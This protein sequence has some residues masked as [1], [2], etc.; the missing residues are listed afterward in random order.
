MCASLMGPICGDIANVFIRGTYMISEVK[1]LA[2]HV[3]I[4]NVCQHVLIGVILV[5]CNA[6]PQVIKK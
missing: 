3:C 1:V 5:V 6:I 2:P 4:G